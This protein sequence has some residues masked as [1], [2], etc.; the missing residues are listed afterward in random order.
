MPSSKNTDH[1]VVVIGGGIAG[2]M[3]ARDLNDAGLDV[4]L[5]EARDRLGG[6]TYYRKSSLVD[7]SVEVGGTWIDLG[8]Y[9]TIAQEVE[10]YNLPITYSPEA[11]AWLTRFDDGTIGEGP[12]PIPFEQ[13]A[14]FE[15]AAFEILTAAKRI[16]QGRPLSQQ[17]LRDLDV[18][19]STYVSS[20]GLPAE[21]RALIDGW[22]ALTTGAKLEEVSALLMLAYIAGIGYSVMGV[23]TLLS[24]KFEAGTSSLVEALTKGLDVRLE[25]PVASVSQDPGSVRVKT[26]DGQELT[27]RA[28]ILATPVNCWVD[29]DFEPRL[30]SVKL[31]VSRGGV[32]GSAFKLWV[33]TESLEAPPLMLNPRD[34]VVQLAY[35]EYKEDDGDLF[36]CFGVARD[37]FDLTDPKVAEESLKRVSP[38]IRVLGTDHHDWI[39]DPYSK[40]TWLAPNAGVLSEHHGEMRRREGRLSF[41]G[42]DIGVRGPGTIDAAASSGAEAASEVVGVLAVE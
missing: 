8:A 41:A 36:A 11:A 30:S 39:S 19:W 24:A 1:D 23:V 17:E 33:L 25:S 26:N 38:D 15:R 10:R 16:D 32:A 27:A 2:S 31:D 28:A 29:V 14:A 13:W 37:R 20:L 6:R 9:P 4:V 22:V 34:E 35:P 21:T 18:P 5:L 3:A 40:G 12:L 42:A 7:H